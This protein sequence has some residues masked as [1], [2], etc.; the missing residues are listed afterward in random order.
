MTLVTASIDC[1]GADALAT[2]SPPPARWDRRGARGP[3]AATGGAALRFRRAD[4][5]TFEV[6][7]AP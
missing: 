3:P 6:I 5:D 1:G 4:A 2:R 7:R